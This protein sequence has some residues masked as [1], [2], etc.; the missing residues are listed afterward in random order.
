MKSPM[1]TDGGFVPAAEKEGYGELEVLRSAAGYYIGTLYTEPEGYKVPGT[2]DSGYYRTRE[3]AE[4]ALVE[5]TGGTLA[6]RMH[7]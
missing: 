3:E 2:R 5:M 1:V 6:P 7:P 4:Q